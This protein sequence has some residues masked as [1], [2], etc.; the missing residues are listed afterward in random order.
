MQRTCPKISSYCHV[1]F[2]SFRCK[3]DLWAILL[4]RLGS[5]KNPKS[6]TWMPFICDA[7]LNQFLLQWSNIERQRNWR[8]FLIP[9]FLRLKSF[10]APLRPNSMPYKSLVLVLSSK[11]GNLL[12]TTSISMVQRDSKIL[13]KGFHLVLS[14]T[15]FSSYFQSFTTY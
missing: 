15:G 10:N 7:V 13:V 9:F 2:N 12:M 3:M 14:C 8:S 11:S 5:N 1:I 4:V 6:I